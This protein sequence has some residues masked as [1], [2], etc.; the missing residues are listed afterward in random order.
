MSLSD[1]KVLRLTFS[2]CCLFS[3]FNFIK[4]GSPSWETL[5]IYTSDQSKLRIGLYLSDDKCFLATCN[6]GLATFC[7]M[8]SRPVWYLLSSCEHL[9]ILRKFHPTPH[10]V[11]SWPELLLDIFGHLFYL[12]KKHF[13]LK[14]I[15]ITACV[16]I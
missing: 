13:P 10:I 9:K 15:C 3:Y 12:L 16:L 4:Y 5:V 6:L 8:F 7:I 2:F 1:H 14:L 11:W